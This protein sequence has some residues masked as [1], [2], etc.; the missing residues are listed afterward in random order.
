MIRGRE[1]VCGDID[2][3]NILPLELILDTPR[4]GVQLK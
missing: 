2:R 4:Q 1:Y 3:E